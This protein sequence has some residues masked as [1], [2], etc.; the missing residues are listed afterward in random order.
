[1][2]VIVS[3]EL[4]HMENLTELFIKKFFFQ[5]SLHAS[6]FEPPMR[7]FPD[8]VHAISTATSLLPSP[9]T[10]PRDT[11]TQSLMTNILSF[12]PP[13]QKSNHRK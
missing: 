7:T 3:I 5:W 12:N 2:Y 8:Q 4:S 11:E 13:Q 9:E 1:M 6:A 10:S